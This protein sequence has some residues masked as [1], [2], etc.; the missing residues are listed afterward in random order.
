MSSKQIL[1]KVSIHRTDIRLS[2]LLQIYW[3]FNS[4]QK[5]VIRWKLAH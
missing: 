5:Y 2:Q 3:E 1:E 4:D